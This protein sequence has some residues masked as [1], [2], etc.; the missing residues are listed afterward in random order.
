ML[1]T[2]FSWPQHIGW[3]GITLVRVGVLSSPLQSHLN[4]DSGMVIIVE[5]AKGLGGEISKEILSWGRGI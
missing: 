3:Y 4:I 5:L 2:S 1:T